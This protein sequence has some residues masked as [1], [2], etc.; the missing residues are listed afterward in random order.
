MMQKPHPKI[1][2]LVEVIIFLI[3]L[4]IRLLYTCKLQNM[5]SQNNFRNIFEKTMYGKG[6]KL[7]SYVPL[8]S[9]NKLISGTLNFFPDFYGQKC[10]YVRFW[11]FTA[12]KIEFFFKNP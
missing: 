3:W 12:M 7:F 9:F 2:F 10:T 6:P 5:I 11:P 8:M 1:L 4:T